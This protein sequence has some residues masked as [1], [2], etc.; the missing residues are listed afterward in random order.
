MKN[1]KWLLGLASLLTALVVF[2]SI[3][4]FT[5]HEKKPA[6]LDTP[7]YWYEFN[8]SNN[9]IGTLLN[10]DGKVT[11]DV[12]MSTLT[13]CPDNSGD[14]CIRGYNTDDQEGNFDSSTPAID[15]R[16]LRQ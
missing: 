8:P 6:K 5:T 11:K 4:A 13:A 2:V 15:H 1:R 3:N 9:E 16:V 10:P 14:I 12:A 7:L